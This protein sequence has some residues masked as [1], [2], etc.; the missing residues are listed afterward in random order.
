MLSLWHPNFPEHPLSGVGVVPAMTPRVGQLV[1]RLLRNLIQMGD[2]ERDRPRK[3]VQGELNDGTW[4]MADEQFDWNCNLGSHIDTD[5]KYLFSEIC[6]GLV[7]LLDEA[8]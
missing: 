6:D 8:Q 3:T 7:G 4:Y 1:S 2:D 5:A